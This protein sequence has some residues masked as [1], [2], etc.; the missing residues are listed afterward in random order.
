MVIR[1]AGSGDHA[2]IRGVT[3]AAFGESR[4]DE[5]AIIEGVRAEG[6][7][8]VEL[9]AEDDGR[10]VGHVLFS[11]MRAD[12]PRA[13]AALGPVAVAPAR[14]RTGIGEALCGAGVEACRA[15]GME[16]VVVLGHPPYY[17]RFGFSAAAAAKLISPYAG[18]PAFMALELKPGAL[19][20]PQKVD[21]P[22]AFG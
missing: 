22:R 3:E 8:L 4:F 6:R 2:M 13:I 7:V 1:E 19:S 15:A 5:A 16:A 18:S 9:V 20:A 11:R 10:I 17:P 14:Q 12:P 21:Y